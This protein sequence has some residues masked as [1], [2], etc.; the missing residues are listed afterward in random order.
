[1]SLATIYIG[2]QELPLTKAQVVV[3]YSMDLKPKDPWFTVSSCFIKEDWEK[4]PHP[5]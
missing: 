4:I 2:R 5:A 3:G 1:M